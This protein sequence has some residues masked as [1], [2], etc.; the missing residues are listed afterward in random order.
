MR[1]CNQGEN[2][3]FFEIC[4]ISIGLLRIEVMTRFARA[5]GSKADNERRPMEATAW[6]EVKRQGRVLCQSSLS[7][8]HEL[9]FDLTKFLAKL[10]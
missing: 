7:D 2:L 3:D 6:S 8:K 4:L 5:K 1:E 9:L 10:S